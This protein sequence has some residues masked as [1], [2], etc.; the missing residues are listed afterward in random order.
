MKDIGEVTS[1]YK[2]NR[3][4]Y[5]SLANKVADILREN[6]EVRKLLLH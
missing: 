6:I 2:R 3:L 4:L 1:W 5:G